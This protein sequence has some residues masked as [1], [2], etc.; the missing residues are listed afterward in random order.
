MTIALTEQ[1]VLSPDGSCK[2]FDSAAN[3]YARGEA[4]NAVLIKRFDDAVDQG[5]PIRAIIRSTSL[6]FDG[7][8]S[9]L[10]QPNPIT[11]EALI[12]QAYKSAGLKDFSRTAFVECHGT[13]TQTGDP[14]ELSAVGNVFGDAEIYIGSVKPNFGHAEGASG[15]TSLIKSVL[16]LEH[17][18]I[19]PNIKFK[20]PNP[21]IDFRSGRLKVPTE[22][23]PW[24]Q[25][26]EARISVNSFGFG[27]SNAHV[28]SM[29][30]AV[31]NEV[32]FLTIH[33]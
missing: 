31:C 27:G 19:P 28:S 22:P 18:T 24:P 3:G 13:G 25:D 29:I 15:L 4:V 11:Q 7:K 26:L 9:S 32:L 20:N 5:N 1:G 17:R 2:T 8:G 12:R 23:I 16:A 30:S 21:H 14:L 33:R 10:G 6:N